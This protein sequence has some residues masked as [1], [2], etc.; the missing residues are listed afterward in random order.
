MFLIFVFSNAREHQ[1]STVSPD[2]TAFSRTQRSWGAEGE[3]QFYRISQHR[4]SLHTRFTA[5]SLLSTAV[6]AVKSTSTA[7]GHLLKMECFTTENGMLYYSFF[8][9][10]KVY[11]LKCDFY[12]SSSVIIIKVFLIVLLIR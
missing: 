12:G 1:E 8:S 7:S 6:T 5:S 10:A 4:A 9:K 2:Q 11:I 3:L